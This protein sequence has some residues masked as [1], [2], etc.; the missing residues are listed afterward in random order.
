M[1]SPHAAGEPAGWAAPPQMRGWHEE[2]NGEVMVGWQPP[3][4]LKTGSAPA[5]PP[6]PL[7]GRLDSATAS[8]GSRC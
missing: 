7:S 4:V 3:R 5:P 1:G 2:G 6:P 8:A